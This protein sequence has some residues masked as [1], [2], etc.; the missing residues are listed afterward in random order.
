MVIGCFFKA[1]HDVNFNGLKLR[2]KIL[3]PI[4][5]W[6]LDD[7]DNLDAPGTRL[8]KPQSR[9]INHLKTYITYIYIDTLFYIFIIYKE[10]FTEA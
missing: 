5:V 7:F 4:Q 1:F 9:N 10:I 6:Y 8:L 3:A 2:E